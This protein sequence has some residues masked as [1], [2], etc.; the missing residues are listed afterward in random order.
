MTW[1]GV[2]KAAK[3]RAAVDGRGR[4]DGT[5]GDGRR[6]RPSVSGE[7]AVALRDGHG[8]ASRPEPPRRVVVR[9]DAPPVV[10]VRGVEGLDEARADDTLRVGVA[11]RDDV[12]VASAELHYT[13]E[14]AA[15]TSTEDE[16]GHVAAALA[17]LG[18]RSARGE[19]ALGLK[20]LGL[21]PGDVVELPGPGR[22][23]TAPPRAGRTWPG[24]RRGG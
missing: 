11:A 3:P 13:I 1:P 15:G 9:P 21:K 20:P 16:A 14:R 23:T 24:R 4:A 6:C 7:Y 22:P 2:E 5:I 19:A 17:G 10:A 8:L 18:T 12:A